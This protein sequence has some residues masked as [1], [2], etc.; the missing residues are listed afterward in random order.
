MKY[1]FEFNE[2]NLT[3]SM[4][5]KMGFVFWDGTG[6]YF[7]GRLWIANKSVNVFLVK[8]M[9]DETEGYG[10]PLYKAEH[11]ADYNWRPIYFLHELYESV[12]TYGDDVTEG[13]LSLCEKLNL[14]PYIDSYNQYLKR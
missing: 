10:D 7:N 2:I 9:D 8:E 12:K 11:F 4:L 3:Y 5:E 1:P 14:M 6:D 13:F